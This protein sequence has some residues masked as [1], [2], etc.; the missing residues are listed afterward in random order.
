MSDY[1][2]ICS[3]EE[4][5]EGQGRAFKVGDRVIAIFNRNGQFHAIDDG[6]PHMAASLSAG[7]F[8]GHVITCPLHAWRFDV[9]D[10]T[11]CDNRQC[12]RVRISRVFM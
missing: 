3:V 5:P 8:E 7:H 9:R 12:R 1:Q 2:R 6:C 11:W 10:G 4:V